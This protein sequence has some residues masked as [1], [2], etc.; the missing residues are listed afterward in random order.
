MCARTSIFETE[1]MF[2]T[3]KSSIKQSENMRSTYRGSTV[4]LNNHQIRKNIFIWKR[5]VREKFRIFTFGSQKMC[6]EIQVFI[7]QWQCTKRCWCCKRPYIERP[8]RTTLRARAPC[9]FWRIR[10]GR[11]KFATLF[12][13]N[14]LAFS[15]SGQED[16]PCL[17]PMPKV[18]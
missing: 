10:L 6:F 8:S 13:T 15:T 12:Q 4:L 11:Q 2:E 1:V 18:E 17:H 7:L 3:W 14:F 16:S 5:F 9:S